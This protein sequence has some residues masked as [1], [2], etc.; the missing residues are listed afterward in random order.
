M[1]RILCVRKCLV[2]LGR[3]VREKSKK[4][5]TLGVEIKIK[6]LQRESVLL[7]SAR[8]FFLVRAINRRVITTTPLV[9]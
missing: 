8:N 2:G 4:S 3:L 5:R 1:G 7:M 6:M 9:F